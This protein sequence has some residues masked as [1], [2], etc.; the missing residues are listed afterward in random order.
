M[1]LLTTFLLFGCTGN[2][3]IPTQTPNTS[4]AVN[5]IPHQEAWGIY[6]LDLNTEEVKLLYNSPNPLSSLQIDASG[7]K[8]AFSQK[9]GGDNNENEE[10]CTININGSNFKRLTNNSI[11]DTYPS[12]S[13]DGSKLIFLSWRNETLDIYLIDADGTNTVLLYDSG[14]HDADIH[15]QNNK[16]AFTRN[17]QIKSINVR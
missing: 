16:I 6:E 17:S 7:T 10:I 9:F 15:W 3:F 2:N 8:F 1:I 11:L 14:F 4:D 12:W 13:S 5:S